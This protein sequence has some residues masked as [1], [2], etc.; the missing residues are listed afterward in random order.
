MSGEVVA[1]GRLVKVTW[2]TLL[3]L[4]FGLAVLFS[5]WYYTY[6]RLSFES[7]IAELTFEQTGPQVYQAHL[8][9]GDRCTVRTFELYGD[10][11]R[12][13]S[14][15][16][17]WKPLGTLLGLDPLYR[18]ERIEGRYRRVEEQNARA[19]RAYALDDDSAIDLVSLTAAMGPFN[20]LFDTSYGSSTYNTMD[21]EYVYQVYETS[22]GIMTRV[23]KRAIVAAEMG[24][25]LS[26]EIN[27]ACGGQPSFWRALSRW[28]NAKLTGLPAR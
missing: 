28:V 5:S 2:F 12:I 18:L 23:E 20:F 22:S 16:V 8:A 26:I 15:F 19:K 9:T 4:L 27:K 21:P 1:V 3:I 17:K 25:I 13:D 6:H 11:W 24:P 7:L 10:Q 14:Q